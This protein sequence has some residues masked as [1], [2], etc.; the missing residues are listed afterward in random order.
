MHARSSE[1]VRGAFPMRAHRPWATFLSLGSKGFEGGRAFPLGRC[2]AA[3]TTWHFPHTVPH[4]K[5]DAALLKP[6]KVTVSRGGLSAVSIPCIA[7]VA[8]S[9]TTWHTFSVILPSAA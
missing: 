7:S 8:L 6:G 2:P 4:V 9:L 1:Q 5:G 3:L